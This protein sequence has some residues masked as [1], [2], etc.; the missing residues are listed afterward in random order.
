[1]KNRPIIIIDDDD[2]DLEL[3][4]EAFAELKIANEIIAFSDTSQFLDFMRTTQ[5]RVFFI[6]CDINMGQT[7]GLQLKEE[8]HSDERLRLKCIPF[9]FLTTSKASSEVM[10]AYSFGVQGFFVKPHT[11]DSIKD[12]LQFMITY[13][14]HS[15]HPNSD[16]HS[17]LRVVG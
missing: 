16:D 4:K 2:D 15:I 14:I 5:K 12:L 13:W 8:I 6:L 17:G 7:S 9:I 11:F 1:M 10:K 3:L